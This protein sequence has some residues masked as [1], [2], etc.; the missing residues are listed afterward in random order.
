MK[1]LLILPTQTWDEGVQAVPSG[2]GPNPTPTAPSDPGQ[3]FGLP[4]ITSENAFPDTAKPDAKPDAKPIDTPVRPPMQGAT[5]ADTETPPPPAPISKTNVEPVA[6]QQAT[7]LSQPMGTIGRIEGGIPSMQ[8]LSS[9]GTPTEI[10]NEPK[11]RLAGPPPRSDTKPQGEFKVQLGGM[12]AWASDNTGVFKPG[13]MANYAQK[14]AQGMIDKMP[15]EKYDK[16]PQDVK[17][18]V[19]A[20]LEGRGNF[21]LNWV[22]RRTAPLMSRAEL[23][24][25]K[26]EMAEGSITLI[27]P[28]GWKTTDEQQQTQTTPE[29]PTVTEPPTQVQPQTPA[30]ESKPEPQSP[31]SPQAPQATPQETPSR[32]P[33]PV[34]P[35][36]SAPP[37]SPS[38]EAPAPVRPSPQQPPV[39]IVP[40]ETESV[41]D[42]PEREP[43]QS[44]SG[45]YGGMKGGVDHNANICMI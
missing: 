29:Q 27:E 11:M 14:A 21:D 10:K 15:K 1:L 6:K 8:S 4:P 20:A 16:L 32:G 19:Q 9:T 33:E 44:S 25:T 17:D 30:P 28:E 18:H 31:S 39:E 12:A 41:T 13:V 34:T 38:T 7:S 5:D 22:I 45:S 24:Q 3:T 35:S 26:K 40:Q 43:A 2:P 36:P 42:D 23:E 37:R